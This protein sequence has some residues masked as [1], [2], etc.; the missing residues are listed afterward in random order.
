M[1]YLP[2]FLKAVQADVASFMCSYSKQLR[3]SKARLAQ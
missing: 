2:P 1:H 3:Y